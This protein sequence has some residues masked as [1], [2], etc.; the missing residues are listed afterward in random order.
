LIRWIKHADDDL[1][2]T[3]A[4][5]R[6]GDVETERVVSPA[7][8][9]D[10]FAVDPDRRLP[11]DGAEVQQDVAIVPILRDL[12]RAAIPDMIVV[13]LN[14]R[15]RRLNRKRHEDFL[16]ELLLLTQPAIPYAI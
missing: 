13:L 1:I 10:L 14:P 7:M 4:L 5:D 2:R 9:A 16:V 15:Q 6:V 3:L 12:K 8:R 11:I